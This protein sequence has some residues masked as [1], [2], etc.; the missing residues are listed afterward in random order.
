V[1]ERRIASADDAQAHRT[2]S[3]AIGPVGRKR[4]HAVLLRSHATVAT[5]PRWPYGR[6]TV[7]SPARS[8]ARERPP[9]AATTSLARNSCGDGCL[10]WFWLDCALLFVPREAALAA[11]VRVRRASEPVAGADGVGPVL[12]GV[13]AAP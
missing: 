12:V 11:G 8:R 10:F 3:S 1:I 9:S 4:C 7:R 6:P 2:G 5:T 13:L